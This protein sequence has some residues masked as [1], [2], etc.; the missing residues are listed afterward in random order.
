[1]GQ[2]PQPSEFEARTNAVYEAL[3]WALSRPGL[4]RNLPDRGVAQVVETLIDMECAVHCDTEEMRGPI[5]R[6]GA[7]IV[8]PEQADHLFF[9]RQPEP[10]I[11][12]QLRMGTDLH[13][14]D[15]ATLIG[16]A[17]LGEGSRLRLT[18]PGCDGPVAI[19]VK[20]LSPAFWAERA[21]ISRYP[22]GFEM[23]LID[24]DRVV[25]VPRSVQVEV[26]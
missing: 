9:A 13:P 11:L 14:E 10:E 26:L 6:C 7:S 23:F 8:D 22:L 20:G 12:R 21:R 18:G 15:G 1:M 17:R 3:M 5:G 4:V 19:A 25:G 24:G 16:T 2:Q